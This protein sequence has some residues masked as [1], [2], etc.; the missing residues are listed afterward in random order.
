MKKVVSVVATIVITSTL[1]GSA[2]ASSSNL[3]DQKLLKQPP[4]AATIHFEG[5]RNPIGNL[6]EAEVEA[7]LEAPHIHKA[8]QENGI[9]TPFH[10]SLTPHTHSITAIT[11]TYKGERNRG[12]VAQTTRRVNAVSTLTYEKSRNISNSFN[13]SIG[14]AKNVVDAAMGYN[15]EY[16]TSEMASYALQLEPNQM[17]S[18][19]LYDMYD[20]TKFD[21]KTTWV[22]SSNPPVLD[23]EYGT[24][25]AEQWTHFGFSGSV[26]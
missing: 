16:S 13:V 11:E 5:E 2:I 9:I 8:D 4:Q 23:Y 1:A 10:F 22:L 25:W 17:G 14:F 7:L 18:I 15:V 24:G 21:V 6:T 26:W 12:V 3:S 20:V 19:T